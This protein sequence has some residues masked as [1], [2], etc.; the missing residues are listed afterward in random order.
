VVE[1]IIPREML[2]IAD[3]AF[4]S[5]TAAEITPIRSIDRIT[6]GSGRRGP[7]AEQLQ[8]AFFGVIHGTREDK[9]RWLSPCH[10]AA[11]AEVGAAGA[12]ESRRRAAR[13]IA[14][15][16][17]LSPLIRSTTSNHSSLTVP[18]W[19]APAMAPPMEATESESPPIL[20]AS[21]A[22]CPADWV[23]KARLIAR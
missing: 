4:F 9:Y 14:A 11:T 7:V 23:T 12:Y 10:V 8:K 1:G 2:Y 13:E 15:S 16:T 5:G 19:S 22:V 6:I 3:E 17:R 18:G 20:A 21:R